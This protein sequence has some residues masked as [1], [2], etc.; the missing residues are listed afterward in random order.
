[1]AADT[2]I[3]CLFEKIIVPIRVFA[4]TIEIECQKNLEI[5]KAQ[6][7][8]V[9]NIKKKVGIDRPFSRKT[10]PGADRAKHKSIRPRGHPGATAKLHKIINPEEWGFR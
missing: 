9:L 5:I 4:K 10:A 1:L 7:S 6:P 8:M 2:F 3:L